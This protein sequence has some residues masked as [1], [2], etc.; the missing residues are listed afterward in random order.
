MGLDN[1]RIEDVAEQ[2]RVHLV[3]DLFYPLLEGRSVTG[4]IICFLESFGIVAS[5]QRQHVVSV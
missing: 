2:H 3:G 4:S 5:A 1:N